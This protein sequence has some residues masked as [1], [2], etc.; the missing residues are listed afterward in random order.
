MPWR[1]VSNS[2]GE[3][4][5]QRGSRSR[6]YS[7][8]RTMASA[9]CPSPA[10]GARRGAIVHHWPKPHM[11]AAAHR[12]DVVGLQRRVVPN[13]RPPLAA[14]FID[15]DDAVAGVILLVP[16]RP[17]PDVLLDDLRQGSGV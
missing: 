9:G 12:P 5:A 13:E 7:I 1:V 3:R 11:P 14:E 8:S 2:V 10:G 4:L 16:V 17:L 6:W 15:S